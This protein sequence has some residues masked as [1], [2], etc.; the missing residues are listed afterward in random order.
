MVHRHEGVYDGRYKLIHFY[1]IDEWELIDTETDPLELNSEFHNPAYA[2]TVV[3][4]K[5]ALKQQKEYYLVP[6]G[7]PAP[8]VMA[9]P[10]KYASPQRRLMES[11]RQ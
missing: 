8:R 4:M 3:R 11:S 2:G 1:D 5:Q 9:D 6:E 7:V 10:L